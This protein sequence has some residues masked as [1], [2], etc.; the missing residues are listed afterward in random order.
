M[1]RKEADHHPHPVVHHAGVPEL[2][3][4]G[5]DDGIAGAAALPGGERLG[6]VPPGEAVEI[7]FAGFRWQGRVIVSRWRQNSR[8]PSSL[9]NFSMPGPIAGLSA[10]AKRAAC[11]T[12][13]GLSSPN[14]KCGDR[15]EVP[16]RSGRSRSP[17]ACAVCLGSRAGARGR[18]LHPASS[19]RAG[20]RPSRACSARAS[21]SPTRRWR[22]S[23]Q[24]AA[25]SARAGFRRIAERQHPPPE[26][27]EHAQAAAFLV[28]DRRGR[29]QQVAGETSASPRQALPAPLRA[30]A[31][32]P[33]AAPVRSRSSRPRALRSH[34]PLQ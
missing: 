24:A 30:V 2:A 21:S 13:R 18:R 7:A 32:L 3:H 34:A 9:R 1:T 8:Q 10:A 25:P 6:V 20:R 5:I 19:S 17:I 28:A 4:A 12:W 11:Q 22:P 26:R 14:L 31:Q 33:D 23:A 16:S 27:R 15:R 29:N